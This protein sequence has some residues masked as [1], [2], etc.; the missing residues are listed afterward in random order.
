MSLD[1][2]FRNIDNYKE[3]CYKLD[4]DGEIIEMKAETNNLVWLTM[5]TG[6]NEITEDNYEIF[7]RRVKYLEDLTGYYISEVNEETG[8]RESL[9]TKE[10]VKKHIGLSTNA[11][12]R[13]R[14]Q[15]IKSVAR[16]WEHRNGDL[17]NK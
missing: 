7:Y 2:D 1:F 4:D 6:I 12:K 8:E 9:V 3:L 17:D 5:N 16:I 14:L 10:L 11:S 13:T 15:F